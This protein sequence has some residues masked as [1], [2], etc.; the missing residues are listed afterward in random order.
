MERRG[1]NA[2]RRRYCSYLVEGS[3]ARLTSEPQRFG[4]MA[5]A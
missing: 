5:A 4:M 2:E 3:T 1:G